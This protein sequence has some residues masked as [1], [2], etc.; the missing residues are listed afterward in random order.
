MATSRICSIPDCGKRVR[1][2]GLCRTHYDRR[3]A[4]GENWDG[5]I[6]ELGAARAFFFES[7][8]LETDE[9]ILWAFSAK[10]KE[11]YGGLSLDG[12]IWR[13]HRLACTLT[14][15]E[16]PTPRHEAAHGCGVP[17]CFNPKHLRWATPLENSADKKIHGTSREGEKAPHAILND[18]L[19]VDLRK[20]FAAGERVSDLAAEVGVTHECMRSAC[21][22][23]T[24]AHLPMPDGMK[25]HYFEATVRIRGRSKITDEQVYA[26]RHDV[27]SNSEIAKDFGL[28]SKTVG[29][30]KMRKLR[31]SLP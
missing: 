7:L 31:A 13:V 26:I 12:K 20:R 21:N 6:A 16:P 28:S 15:G 24:W 5:P 8:K 2:C 29:K 25:P 14:H 19:V 23:I 30:I 4:G 10:G 17:A 18:A 22:G 27:R 1:A 9:C 3:L 11:G